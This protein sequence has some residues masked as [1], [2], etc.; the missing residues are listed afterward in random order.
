MALLMLSLLTYADVYH[1]MKA[2]VTNEVVCISLKV[3]AEDEPAD[4]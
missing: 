1:I 2:T 3:G 4:G